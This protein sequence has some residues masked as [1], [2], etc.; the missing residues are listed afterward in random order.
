MLLPVTLY[1][2]S[3]LP[4]LQ[5]CQKPGL[6]KHIMKQ[7][8]IIIIIIIKRRPLHPSFGL[9]S[10]HRLQFVADELAQRGQE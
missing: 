4:V 1:P 8:F 9:H 10:V 2:V 3:L 5:V 7:F 6:I